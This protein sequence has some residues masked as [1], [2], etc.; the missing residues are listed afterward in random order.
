MR[1]NWREFG[2]F[3]RM[4]DAWDAHVGVNTVRFPVKLSLYALPAEELRAVLDELERQAPRLERELGRNKRVWFDEVDRIRAKVRA[5]DGLPPIPARTR[6]RVP[7]K[8]AFVFAVTGDRHVAGLGPALRFLKQFSRAEIV[9]VQARST[10]KAEHDQVIEAAIPDGF[11]DHEAS[12]L[13]KTDL[14]SRVGGLAERF[15]YLDSDVI[16]VRDDVDG[17][18]DQLEGPVRFARD[19]TNLDGFSRWAVRCGCR[20]D[21]CHHLREALACTFGIDVRAC[22]WGLWNGGVFVFDQRARAFFETWR[23]MALEAFDDPYWATRD[24]GVLAGAAWKLGLQDLAPLPGRFNFI[25]DRMRGIPLARRPFARAADFH[26]RHDFSVNGTS[27]EVRPSL[28]HFI[29]G[30]VGQTG[31]RHWDDV[32]RLLAPDPPATLQH[33]LVRASA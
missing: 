9:V 29:N 21:G 30:G 28:I 11:S 3:C 22:D 1:N 31:W 27:S 12:I 5:A 20:E 16:A 24:Q 18:F 23:D 4:A 25:V 2:D 8:R 14:L 26:V 17:V 13:L 6:A 7:A 33:R 32:Q 19:H 10:L 15:C